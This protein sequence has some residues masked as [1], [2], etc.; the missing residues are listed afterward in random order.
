M[1][2]RALVSVSDK[3]GLI[4]FL[5]PLVKQGL[6]IVS[7]G[8]TAEFLKKQSWKITDISEVT[9]FPE[10]LDGRV[11]TL[12][13][14]VHMGLLA[15]TDSSD[16]MNTLK[17]HQVEMFDL[18][19]GNLYPFEKALQD[20]LKGQDLIEKIDIGGPSFL[21]SAA[22]NFSSVTV[23]C[24]PSDYIWI[25]KKNYQLDLADRQI[26][27]SRVFRLASD[28]DQMIASSLAGQVEDIHSFSGKLKQKLRYG[29]NEQQT[30]YWFQNSGKKSGLTLVEQL[31]GKELSYNNLLDLD[32]AL[33]FVSQF[34][35][36]AA[37]AVK[38]NNPC[39][40]AYGQKGDV[41]LKKTLESDPVSVF[42]GVVATN[43]TVSAQQADLLNSL[44]IECVLA[45]DFSNEALEILKSKKNIRLLKG[46]QEIFQ[47]SMTQEIRSIS[48]GFLLQDK[49][50][51]SSDSKK[52]KI[53]GEPLNSSMMELAYFGEA[54]C[55]SLKSNAIAIVGYGQALG[56]GMGQVNR[57]DAV[58]QA[59]Q[60][61]KKNHPNLNEVLLVSDAF[62]PF[63]DSIEKC[64]D[65]GIRWILQPG[66]SIKD[67]EVI[68]RA[69]DLKLNMILTGQRHFRH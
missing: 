32:A 35:M 66:G 44:F 37:V 12:H 19:V 14:H 54:V 33:N 61:W 40:A 8:G 29:E 4:E 68:Q 34:R 26:L 17:T 39:G 42:G 43:F 7:T 2:K 36:P 51:G 64:F 48:G 38:H 67:G 9:K 5:E 15:K 63:S 53:I 60:R 46:A 24:R 20:N 13:P 45:P 22:K 56:L 69:T 23:V 11:K 10:V 3:T 59:I 58:E 16:H 6:E 50:F 62:F 25:Q 47:K 65:A 27:A 28:Y 18:V 52:W 57:V 41:V 21:R 31:N 55:A 1:F 30:G 49:D